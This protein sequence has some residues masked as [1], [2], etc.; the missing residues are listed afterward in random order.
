VNARTAVTIVFALNGLL[1][2]A[3]AAR[4][5][6]VG[7]RL[8]LDPGEL[9]IAL[10]FI[11][12]GALVA[13]PISGRA[14]SRYGS[15][16]TTTVALMIFCVAAGLAPAAPSLALL[17]AACALMGAGGGALDVAMNAHAVAVERVYGRPILS[18]FHAFFSLGGLIGALLGA[19]GAAVAIDARVELAALAALS[20]VIGAV[21]TRAL[22]PASADAGGKRAPRAERPR[23]RIDSHLM[24]L[25][26]LA[27]FCLMCE[28]AAADWSAVYVDR[29]LSASAATAG[30]A[31]A[32][33]SVTMVAVRFA[34]DALTERF[35]PTALVRGGAM[36]A[37]VG[38]GLALV[39]ASPAAALFGFACLGAGMSIVIPQ[40]FRAAA[41]TAE[42]GQ[43]GPAL[44]TV[45]TIGYT[46]FLAGPPLIGAFAHL[47]SLP[48]ALGVLPL[49]ALA[50]VVL[51]PATSRR[52]STSTTRARSELQP[53]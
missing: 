41:G 7:N 46:G 15:R 12:A 33:F 23:A 34:G 31:F 8:D 22:L 28:G 42:A 16:A 19:A 9:G 2:G 32:A 13:M 17:C 4:L 38:L 52:Q 35:G 49:L 10:G 29:D 18:T 5:A 6:A 14:T 21:A 50:M 24:L 39:V 45:T 25:G 1:Y 47:T 37:A 36:V 26:A 40:V 43:S 30:L 48:L 44:A 27:F 53:S 3:W 11:A 20:V 51:A